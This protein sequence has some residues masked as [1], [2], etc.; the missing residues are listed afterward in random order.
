MSEFDAGSWAKSQWRETGRAATKFRG[1]KDDNSIIKLNIVEKM[2][3]PWQKDLLINCA[4]GSRQ[5]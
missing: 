2:W 5:I 3:K 1:K 4:E